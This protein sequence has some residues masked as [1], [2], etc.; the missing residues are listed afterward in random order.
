[1]NA[2]K[3]L[4]LRAK[5]WHLFIAF[6][7]IAIVIFLLPSDI[8]SA[9]GMASVIVRTGIFSISI[10]IFV[11]WLWSLGS[12]LASQL[13]ATTGPSNL[14][15]IACLYALLYVPISMV[16]FHNSEPSLT[17]IPQWLGMLYILCVFYAFYYLCRNFACLET[18]SPQLK[19]RYVWM[20]FS[21]LFFPIGVWVIQPK[22]NRMWHKNLSVMGNPSLS[23]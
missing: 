2:I 6:A 17:S 15:A 5:S 20:F 18:G 1:M 23:G 7:T 12:F 14:F 4:F 16:F 13:P 11:G 10:L 19:L 21:F 9:G 22:V 3:N 8:A